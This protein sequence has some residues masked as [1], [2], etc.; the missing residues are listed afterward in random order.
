MHHP[1]KCCPRGRGS[2][3]G[4]FSEGLRTKASSSEWRA[5]QQPGRLERVLVQGP[6]ADAVTSMRDAGH[7]GGIAVVACV[8]PSD[9]H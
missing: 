5:T 6:D 2:G 1:A 8:G 3:L 9:A 4:G 7:A